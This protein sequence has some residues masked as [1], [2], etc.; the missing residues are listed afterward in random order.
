VRQGLRALIDTTP[1]IQVVGEAADGLTAVQQANT[2]HPDIII[3][4]LVLPGL[5]GIEAIAAIKQADAQARILVLTNFSDEPRV[6]AALRAGAQGYLLKDAILTDV[7][8]AIREVFAGKLTLHPSINHILIRAMQQ[9]PEPEEK[10]AVTP[11]LTNREQDVLQL[12]AK[13]F[14]NQMIADHLQIDERTV[15]IH[16]SHILQKLGLENRTQAAL[17]ALRHGF[18]SLD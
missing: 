1:D 16:V 5:D 7:L 6:L 9:A 17:Y 4:D 15:R 18:A 3:M 8:T 14:T 12:V 13:G 2:L 11:T 10:T